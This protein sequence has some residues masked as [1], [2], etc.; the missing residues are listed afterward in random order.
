MPRVVL[1]ASVEDGTQ[2]EKRYRSHG[3]VFRKV[4]PGDI[5]VIHFT[6]TESNEIVMCVDV[7]DIDGYF[8]MLGSPEIGWRTTES[9]ATPS[10]SS[11]WTRPRPS[12]DRWHPP[13]RGRPRRGVAYE[14]RT[15]SISSVFSLT[16][17]TPAATHSRCAPNSSVSIGRRN[18][19]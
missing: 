1:T 15:R 3:D 11:C 13:A 9:I 19:G 18:G 8:R 2:W 10:K 14:A 12:D 7:E 6:I 4:W 5:P 17:L 16:A